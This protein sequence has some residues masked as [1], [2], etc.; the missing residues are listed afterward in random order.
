M[1]GTRTSGHGIKNHF[2]DISKMVKMGNAKKPAVKK[3]K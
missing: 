2:A 3:G 1:I